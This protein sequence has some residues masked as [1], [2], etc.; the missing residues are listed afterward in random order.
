[1]VAE[2]GSAT[3][4]NRPD[5]T[6]NPSESSKQSVQHTAAGNQN[7]KPRENLQVTVSVE[8]PP[9]QITAADAPAYIPTP[10]HQLSARRAPTSTVT[11]DSVQSFNFSRLGTHTNDH[12]KYE[13]DLRARQELRRKQR[14]ERYQQQVS[15][16]LIEERKRE[17]DQLLSSAGAEYQ[18][19]F[20]QNQQRYHLSL[21][22]YQQRR[23]E[24]VT[25]N[26]QN[27]IV[28]THSI[29]SSV[30]PVHPM[31]THT[32]ESSAQTTPSS[33]APVAPNHPSTFVTIPIPQSTPSTSVHELPNPNTVIFMS[34]NEYKALHNKQKQK[35]KK[36]KRNYTHSQRRRYQELKQKTLEEKAK[37]KS[38]AVASKEP[39]SSN[40]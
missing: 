16:R 19:D 20:A 5:N 23:T 22:Q 39:S 40:Q 7:K 28:S 34:V 35:K 6:I 21:A 13:R 36:P 29:D 9:I 18:T 3:P 33:A 14:Q 8:Q 26:S 1:M 24:T 12:S 27:Q 30:P 32:D 15:Q 25:S 31:Q 4:P 11:S 2:R 38:S 10:I 17:I 37:E